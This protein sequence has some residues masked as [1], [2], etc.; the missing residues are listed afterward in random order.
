MGEQ[1]NFREKGGTTMDNAM[2]HLQKVLKNLNFVIFFRNQNFSACVSKVILTQTKLQNIFLQNRIEENRICY[3][4]Q[5]NF[6]V[7]ILQK[8]KKRY[9]ENLNQKCVAD[10]K[11]FWKTVK[12]LLSDKAA[13]K[14]GIH[15]IENNDLVKTD[16]ATAEVLNNFFFPM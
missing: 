2:E 8:T 11:L 15:L 4:K 16:L 10:N 9:Y 3:T 5:R 7:F 6:C 13:G 14:K 12:P 1:K